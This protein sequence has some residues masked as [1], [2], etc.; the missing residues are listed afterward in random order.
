MPDAAPRFAMLETVRE[1]GLAQLAESGEERQTRQRHAAY[2]E[3]AV[4]QITPTP[5]MPASEARVRWIYCRARQPAGSA[6]LAGQ[7]G[8]I[9]RYLLL[10]TRL[11]PLWSMLGHLG[12]GRRY[13]EQG[14]A[15]GGAV[16]VFLRGMAWRWP[17][18]WSTISA[19]PSAVCCCCEE[20]LALP[21]RSTI[22]RAKTVRTWRWVCA[23]LAVVLQGQGRY[24]EAEQYFAQSLTAFRELGSEVNVAFSL[25]QL[26][27]AAYGR[28]DLTRARAQCRRAWR[29]RGRRG[30]RCSSTTRW[31][32]SA[33]SPA[34]VAT[35]PERPPPLPRPR[36]RGRGRRAPGA[37][38]RL[39]SVAV[40]AVGC[41]FPEAAARLLGAAGIQAR[42]L[43]APFLLPQRTAY[44]RATAAARAAL[45]E[46]RFA[47]AWAA[48]QTLTREAAVAEAR[49]FVAALEPAPVATAP[50]GPAVDHGLTPRELDVL[51]LLVEGRTDREIAARLFVSRNTAA[52]HVKSILGK[53][54]VPSRAAAAAV[55]VRR[56]LA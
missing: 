26:G 4:E 9:E 1:Y 7:V 31:S 51:R 55:A 13:L 56:G 15:R 25:C 33:S 23:S 43:G 40:L 46:D 36:A 17:E 37:R 3:A 41:G 39:A 2:Y 53:L 42:A 35:T 49:T 6:G 54:D 32:T 48:G 34:P 28:G 38:S 14:V 18:R 29:W 47:A 52:N 10:A 20:G 45:G 27:L 24:V 50:A 12:E 44:E 21:G 16:P 8:E 30:A 5:R 11:W 19:M 22:R